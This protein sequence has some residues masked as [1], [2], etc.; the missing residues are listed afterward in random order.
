MTVTVG[1]KK[2]F[3]M[4][5]V[6][7]SSRAAVYQGLDDRYLAIGPPSLAGLFATDLR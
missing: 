1:S 3:D 7:P 6:N 5:L 4:Q 2:P